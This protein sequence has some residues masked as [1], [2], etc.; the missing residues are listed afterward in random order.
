MNNFT[1]FLSVKELIIILIISI[2]NNI[3]V[4]AKAL[5][6]TMKS[7]QDFSAL[8]LQLCWRCWLWPR[9]LT[10]VATRSSSSPPRHVT[11]TS[12]SVSHSWL[13]L[14]LNSLSPIISTSRDSDQLRTSHRLLK[15]PQNPVRNMFDSRHP[16]VEDPT[17]CFY[18]PKSPRDPTHR[19]S[20]LTIRRA[21][22]NSSVNVASMEPRLLRSQLRGD[23]SC[24]PEWRP[25]WL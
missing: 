8:E 10:T 24:G 25:T 22:A 21:T 23:E 4:L 2:L 12:G 18:H 15:H 19:I 20:R 5:N 3:N 1:E 17:H 16:F 11:S 13:L 7:D 14:W 6:R 9:R